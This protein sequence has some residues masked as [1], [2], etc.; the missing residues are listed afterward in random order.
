[1]AIIFQATAVATFD[2]LSGGN[3]QRIFDLS[4]GPGTDSIWLGNI[5]TS[6]DIRFEVE[7]DGVRHNIIVP[8]AIDEGVSTEW[9]VT[10]EDTGTFTIFKDGTQTAS[11]NLGLSAIP[12]DV[13]RTQSL[14][15][16][17]PHAAD[18]PLI[19]TIDS[20]DFETTLTNGFDMTFTDTVNV[21]GSFDG[22]DQ[23]EVLD[24]SAKTTATTIDGDAGDDTNSGG[25]GD[26]RSLR[27]N[28]QGKDSILGGEDGTGLEDD[29]LD[30]SGVTTGG[31]TVLKG[32]SEDGTLTSAD[33]TVSFDEIE[34][35]VL[36]DQADSYDG[37]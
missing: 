9:R 34:R 15:G 22:T 6:D 23:A 3:F 27:S 31:V 11:Q 30:A 14:I 35:F 8:N 17:S 5:F 18:D 2:N 1:M 20:I 24:A 28:S 25:T 33:G 29:I 13:P 26:D 4:N 10:I 12:N 19:G 36:T 7:Q 21:A 32:S 37:N 16:D